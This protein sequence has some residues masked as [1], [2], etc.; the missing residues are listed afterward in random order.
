MLLHSALIMLLKLAN[1]AER[2]MHFRVNLPTLQ[3]YRKQS[4][5]FRVIYCLKN[6]IKLNTIKF[7]DIKSNG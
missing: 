2:R 1:L 4:Y 6:S 3:T 5:Q 7:S